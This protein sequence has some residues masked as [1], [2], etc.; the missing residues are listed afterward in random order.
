MQLPSGV[1]AAIVDLDGTLVDTLGDFDVALNAMLGDLSLGPVDRGF[2]ERTVGKGSEHLIRSTLSHVG[3]DAGHFD[4]AWARYQNHYLAINGDCAQVYPGVTEGLERLRQRGIKLACLTNK[5][6]AFAKPL[7]QKKGLSGFFEHVFGGDAFER[8]NPDPLP[9]IKTCEALGT[10]PGH[11][12]MVGDSSN[13]AR[14]ARAAGCPV[15]LVSY[16][17]NHGEPVTGVDTD[18]VIARLDELGS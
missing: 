15:V 2:I 16:G 14:A 3:G 8:K 10:L 7:L 12:L 9:L 6:T 5:P 1:Q 4:A 17:Y 18:G 13:D 11:T